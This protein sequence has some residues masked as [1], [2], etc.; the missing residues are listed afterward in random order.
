M[1]N[2]RT[3][4]IWI[5]TGIYLLIMAVLLT[6]AIDQA[7]FLV[8]LYRVSASPGPVTDFSNLRRLSFGRDL[9]ILAV[10]AAILFLLV[11]R[12]LRR[13][14]P[15]SMIAILIFM[16]LNLYS[17]RHVLPQLLIWPAPDVLVEQYA[18]A[19]AANDLEAALHLTDGSEACQTIMGPI[20]QAH[21]AQ[22]QQRL[23]DDRPEMS[24]KNI[25]VKSITTFYEK[26]V[27]QGF[28]LM[29]PGPSQL[30]TVMAEMEN[31]QTIWL[32]L[33]LR[34]TPFWGTRYICG[35]DIDD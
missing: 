29:Q 1:R 14:L 5:L 30:V 8:S 33:K 9:L 21:Q 13:L 24:I 35:Q 34:Y 17:G 25:S 22:F 11:R 19:L 20:F 3:G 28:V 23:A 16:V 27:S 7:Y 2:Y 6:L 18:Q 26:P 12:H 32:N 10:V 4:L 15:I 31:G